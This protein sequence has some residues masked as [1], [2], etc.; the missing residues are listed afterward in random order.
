MLKNY[1]RY[2]LHVV[3]N[4]M[5]LPMS[6]YFFIISISCTFFNSSQSQRTRSIRFR[7]YIQI[8]I[9]Y[10]FP[11]IF[12]IL[13]IIFFISVTVSICI[14][15]W[16]LLPILYLSK[17]YYILMYKLSRAHYTRGYVEEY[18]YYILLWWKSLTIKVIFSIQIISTFTLTL[19]I[20]FLARIT[21]KRLFKIHI[22]K[23]FLFKY[24]Q[25]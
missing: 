5:N 25:I 8:M 13:L 19:S 7:I 12:Q 22:N 14:R 10:F 4:V 17:E 2:Y 24:Y 21:L 16:M 18:L 9:I 3:I 1:S 20:I 6:E 23:K 15:Y 11:K